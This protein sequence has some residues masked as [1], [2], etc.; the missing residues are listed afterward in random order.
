M[1]DVYWILIWEDSTKL[2]PIKVLSNQIERLWLVRES[3]FKDFICIA[4]FVLH[5]L[6]LVFYECQVSL[7]WIE[8]IKLMREGIILQATK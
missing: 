1:T 4:F 7:Y 6:K 8:K 2:R 3:T 5:V